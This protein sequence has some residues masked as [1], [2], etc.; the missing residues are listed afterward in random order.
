MA[1]RDPTAEASLAATRALRRFGI[2]MAATMMMIPTT[3]SSSRIEKPA[4]FLMPLL[5]A[6]QTSRREYSYGKVATGRGVS[7]PAGR[8]KG[9]TRVQAQTGYREREKC[10]IRLTQW[11]GQ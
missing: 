7:Q 3:M 5:C 6:C 11:R 2:A 10:R 4:C 8:R 1:R 9:G